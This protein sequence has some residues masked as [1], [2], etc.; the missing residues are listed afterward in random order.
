LQTGQDVIK[1]QEYIHSYETAEESPRQEIEELKARRRC[2]QV[3]RGHTILSMRS[4]RNLQNK[5][6]KS[7]RLAKMS[8]KV[9]RGHRIF[10]MKLQ[11]NHQNRNLKRTDILCMTHHLL[12]SASVAYCSP[13]QN[14]SSTAL[15]CAASPVVSFDFSVQRFH[16]RGSDAC[17]CCK[18][19]QSRSNQHDAENTETSNAP[20]VLIL[21]AA[22]N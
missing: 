14:F 4:Q 10:S 16:T 3:S 13:L 8:P 12:A 2:I 9:R 5:H 18:T 11:R 22:L 19:F 1:D 17:Q 15:Q 6:L 7:F 20:N 21:A